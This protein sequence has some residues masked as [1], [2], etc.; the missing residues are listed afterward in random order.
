[1]RRARLSPSKTAGGVTTAGK[2]L[3]ASFFCLAS[4]NMA[5]PTFRATWFF[6]DVTY[7]YGWTENWWVSATDAPTASV[8]VTNYASKRLAF[9]MDT[10]QWTELRISNIDP[11]RDSYFVAPAS[12]AFG[13][14]AHATINPAGVWDTLLIRRDIAGNTLLGHQFL[15][16]VPAAIFNGRIY[17]AGGLPIATWLTPYSAWQTEVQ[18]GTYLLKKKSGSSFVYQACAA[19]TSIRRTERRVGRPFDGLR[20][21]RLTA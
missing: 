13:S 10:A 15:H 3:H 19:I 2:G 12:A 17:N 16:S 1:M 11:P 18:S 6:Q 4:G 5:M 8:N 21:R 14:I 20:G 7:G 9:M